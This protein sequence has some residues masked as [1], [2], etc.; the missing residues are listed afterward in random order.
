MCTLYRGRNL[1]DRIERKFC[2]ISVIILLHKGNILDIL[3][4]CVVSMTRARKRGGRERERKREYPQRK[5]PEVEE[6]EDSNPEFS[7]L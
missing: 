6:A 2:F 7:G 5:G 4:A 3:F 1:S